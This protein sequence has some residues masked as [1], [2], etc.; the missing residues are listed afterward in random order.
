MG[1]LS[2]AKSHATVCVIVVSVVVLRRGD[3]GIEGFLVLR[4]A[5]EQPLRFLL[6]MEILRARERRTQ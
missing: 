1:G 6:R 4:D 5:A 3:L 2:N